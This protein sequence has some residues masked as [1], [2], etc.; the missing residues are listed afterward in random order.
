MDSFSITGTPKTPSIRF[1]P[2][3]GALEISGRSTPEDPIEF[4]RPLLEALSKLCVTSSPR[5]DVTIA[6]EYF[7]TSS[8]RCIYNVFKKL[9]IYSKSGGNVVV[10]WL[11]EEDDDEFLEVGEDF[12]AI[13]EVPFK[14]VPVKK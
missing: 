3:A 8:S 5:C 6:F 14:M 4:Y 11:Y 12:Q 10:N 2:L 1:D 7:S 9:E 13:I